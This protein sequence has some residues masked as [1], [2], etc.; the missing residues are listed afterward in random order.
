MRTVLNISCVSVGLEALS[1]IPHLQSQYTG[2]IRTARA[3][4]SFRSALHTT[5]PVDTQLQEFCVRINHAQTAHHARLTVNSEEILASLLE[6]L[7]NG[8]SEGT[9]GQLFDATAALARSFTT[10]GGEDR[11]HSDPAL[12]TS[13]A[14]VGTVHG[15]EGIP[16]SLKK[17]LP[18]ISRA[19]LEVL[20]CP[21]RRAHTWKERKASLEVITSLAVL[22][23][24]RGTHGPLGEYRAK[25]IE[26]ASRGKHDS[27]A[28]VREA[29]V[30]SLVALEA[31]EAE[32]GKREIRRPHSAPVGVG[33]FAG[34][35]TEMARKFGA[36]ERGVGKDA[37]T[38]VKTKA[39]DSI[40][41]KAEKAKFAAAK[42]HRNETECDQE[43]PE[44][45]MKSRQQRKGE[46]VEAVDCLVPAD[47]T[48]PTLPT[49]QNAMPATAREQQAP[50]QSSPGNLETPLHAVGGNGNARK[51]DHP[52]TADRRDSTPLFPENID[53]REPD[54][55]TSESPERVDRQSSED[56]APL[57]RVHDEAAGP[58]AKER[59]VSMPS[60]RS[61]G[62]EV[63]RAPVEEV[64]ASVSGKQLPQVGLSQSAEV[65]PQLE[66][67]KHLAV[68]SG[69]TAGA[70]VKVGS[71]PFPAPMHGGTHVDTLRL[72]KHL[73]SKTDKITSVLDGLDQRLLGVERTLVVRLQKS[74][75][76]FEMLANELPRALSTQALAVECVTL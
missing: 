29:A 10:H 74:A 65:V 67:A 6:A 3:L 68:A 60:R 14:E 61:A 40:I 56:K 76:E 41:R 17:G 75:F 23:D 62:P 66:E 32:E 53:P 39:L 42:A 11:E 1:V 50:S 28:A 59:G 19:V 18:A 21:V 13:P 48:S 71:S 47:S 8:R 35:A 44:D 55:V 70:V 38:L 20:H 43:S 26:G 27:V 34:S 5:H 22:S 63:M 49:G 37:G 4:N 58:D 69:D 2:R 16:A 7:G 31:T 52:N 54:G 64:E 72:L 33:R 9:R 36:G 30:E 12:K 24:L 46:A 51:S 73:D 57:P 25:L 15:L 45:G